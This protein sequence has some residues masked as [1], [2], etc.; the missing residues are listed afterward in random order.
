M[1]L[2]TEFQP[3]SKQEWLQ[4]VEKDLKGKPL[5]DLNWHLNDDITLMPFYHAD[6]A[7]PSVGTI[8]TGAD[9]Q[10]WIGEE[11][12]VSDPKKTNIELLA[13]LERG[14]N[15]P[16]FLIN[17]LDA[18]NGLAQLFKNVNI[19]IIGV[20][21]ELRN[22]NL[23]PVE[24]LEAYYQFA[25]Q[26]NYDPTQLH[27]CLGLD[28]LIDPTQCSVSEAIEAIYF[29][30]KNLPLFRVFNIQNTATPGQSE[31]VIEA[32]TA[33]VSQG[34][35]YLEILK[36]EGLEPARIIARF[37]FSLEIGKSYF[38]EIAALRA[39]KVLWA[40]VL[41]TY[42]CEIYPIYLDAFL[43]DHSFGDDEYTNMIR[44]TTQAMSAVIGGVNR[45]TIPPANTY[46]GGKNDL[47][48]RVAR[49]V[50]HILQLESHL[51]RV[52]DPAAGSY[53]IEHLTNVLIEKVW[54]KLG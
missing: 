49:N 25:I 50:Q 16:L 37:Q 45:L 18:K 36:G 41:K 4:K 23:K 35:N 52:Q 7:T 38:V 15:T 44:A 28:P 10:W 3:V 11:F 1:A 20:H 48:E 54:S 29:I 33:H 12:K 21:F 46:L 42:G 27:G 39:F 19:A 31:T 43:V 47:T 14:V 17:E 5:A 2:F 30:E 34:I 9:N 8:A 6:D 26:N 24:L 51:D 32:L 22:S 53:Y 40:N 13:A